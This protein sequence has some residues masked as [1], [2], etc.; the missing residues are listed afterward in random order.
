MTP[1]VMLSVDNVT[2]CW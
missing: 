2:L 1:D